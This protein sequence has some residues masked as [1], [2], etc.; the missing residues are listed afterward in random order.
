ME[1]FQ[2][3]SPALETAKIFQ[4]Q[5]VEFHEFTEIQSRFGI[6][7]IERSEFSGLGAEIYEDYVRLVPILKGQFTFDTAVMRGCD[8]AHGIALVIP[9]ELLA[10]LN[11]RGSGKIR[12]L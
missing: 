3:P 8:H 12:R 4:F 6:A 11:L 7:V 10:N 9:D 2:R 5:I 1:D